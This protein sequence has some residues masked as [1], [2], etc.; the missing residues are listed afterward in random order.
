MSGKKIERIID[1]EKKKQKEQ[2]MLIKE[3][4]DESRRTR[5]EKE[6]AELMRKVNYQ[7]LSEIK[8]QISD[9]IADL[10]VI[11][12]KI[13]KMSDNATARDFIKMWNESKLG[14]ARNLLIGKN[15]IIDNYVSHLIQSELDE[16]NE[17]HKEIH[18]E[19]RYYFGKVLVEMDYKIESLKKY[20]GDS[21]SYGR[22]SQLISHEILVGEK[23]KE[24]DEK[25]IAKILIE[26]IAANPSRDI[27]LSLIESVEREWSNESE[28]DL[29]KKAVRAG[30]GFLVCPENKNE[31]QE[32]VR[33]SKLVGIV[34]YLKD[35]VRKLENIKSEHHQMKEKKEFRFG[36]GPRKKENLS[37]KWKES[38][39]IDSIEERVV[40]LERY[41]KF[42]H[43]LVTYFSNTEVVAEALLTAAEDI[44]YKQGVLEKAM[45]PIRDWE[46]RMTELGFEFE[47]KGLL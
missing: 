23:L 9:V 40:V 45:V 5:N 32:V 7:G 14:T 41:I 6:I 46:R 1:R 12:R 3:A 34:E 10:T 26:E 31:T 44:V 11:D 17:H 13:N 29:F 22:E 15:N 33:L 37:A 36:G 47:V 25:F 28:L 19:F 39:E 20:L 24:I 8:E 21:Y 18:F 38:G 27:L 42:C 35:N 4:V 16:L 2:F 30:E 43:M